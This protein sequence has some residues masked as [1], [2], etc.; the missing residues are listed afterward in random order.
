MPPLTFLVRLIVV[1]T[2][3]DH[4]EQDML[5]K[6]CRNEKASYYQSDK[7]TLVFACLLTCKEHHAK[8]GV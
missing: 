7:K 4:R 5:Q 8:Y 3:K 2:K 1:T 6:T